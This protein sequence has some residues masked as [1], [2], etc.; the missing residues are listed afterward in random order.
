MIRRRRLRSRQRRSRRHLLEPLEI[1]QLLAGNGTG[2]SATYFNGTNLSNPVLTRVDPTVNFDWGTGSPGAGVPS[3]GF[4]ARWTGQVEITASGT[5]TF[6]TNSDD[7]VRLWVNG[8]QLVNNWTTHAATENSG[9]I[10]LTAGQKYDVT[11]EYFE[12]QFGA[13][14]QLSW[15]SAGIAK[16]IIP[17]GALFPSSSAPQPGDGTGL[18]ATYFSDMGLTTSALTRVDPTINFD[19][20]NGSPG[21][22]VPTDRFS[23]RWT[24]Q[25]QPPATGTY[26]FYTNADDGV[27]LW[28]NGQLLVD[29]WSDH[30]PRER[31]GTI[32]LVGGQKYDL[33]V[34]YYENSVGASCQVLWSSS[35]IAKQIVPQGA[36]FPNTTPD[37]QPPSVPGTPTLV[38]R[39][40]T[41]ISI[42]W[43]ASTDNVGVAGYDV[44]RGATKAGST[45]STSFTDSGLTPN[46]SY[47]YTVVA[48]DA[49]GNVSDASG[50]LTAT[51]LSTP[52][53]T[54]GG[55]GLNA[56]YFNGTNLTNPVLTRTDPTVNFDWGNGSPGA[57]VP[58]DNFSARWTGQVQA[59][60][61]GSYTFYTTSDDG[62]RLS[63]NGQQLVNNWTQHAPTENS[64]TISLVAGQKYDLVLEFFENQFGATCTFSWQGPG[65]AKQIVPQNYL[66]G[67]A[68]DQQNPSTPS[69]LSMVSR[70]D[71]SISIQWNAS[72]DNVGVAAY[73]VYR[74][75]ALAGSV[76]AP[77]TSFTD[78]N[79][80]PSTTYSYDVVARDAAGNKS[81]HSSPLS[82]TTLDSPPPTGGGTGLNATYFSNVN[83]A[84]VALT[85]VDPTINFDWGTGS[86]GAGVPVDFF[87]ARWVGQV[88]PTTSGSYTFFTNS[89]DG[90][91]LWVNGQQLVNNW[92]QHGPTENSGS[93]TLT[94]GQ[95]YD[96]VIEYYENQFGAVCQL[97]WQGP[98]VA[99]QIVPQGALFGPAADPQ[100]PSQPTGVALV[101]KTDTR[102]TIQWN[103]STDNVGVAGYDI[104]RGTTKVGSVGPTTLTFPDTGLTANTTYSYTVVAFDQAGNRSNP[105]GA[106]SVT[107]NPTSATP[108]PIAGNW[109]LIFNDDFNSINSTVWS[110]RYWW[111]GNN[112]TDA[113]FLPS[114]IS[115]SNGVLN[116]TA[117]KG[118]TTATDGITRHYAS[119]LLQSGGIQ[120]VKPAGFTFQ[121]GYV[122]ASSKVAAGNSMWSALW[123]LPANYQD[124]HELDLFENLGRAPTN[125]NSFFHWGPTSNYAGRE[126]NTGKNLTQDFHT[127]GVDWEPDHI[128]WYID[129]QPVWSYTNAA[130]IIN[131]P[132]YLILNLDVGGDWAGWPD[133][134]TPLQSTWQVDYLRV[135]QKS[136]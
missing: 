83:L 63:I 26:T 116:I 85:R 11:L 59:P 43:T 101:S 61:T 38:S 31:S 40:D 73:D 58:N 76:T 81:Q 135:W 13:V 115:V 5:Y 93:I 23:A 32:A 123:M 22:G 27:R 18:S 122:E 99:K 41:Q 54:G 9:S 86:P 1:R 127:Y 108:P 28:V 79:L 68:P 77:G 25:V 2:L 125:F 44:Y 133:G 70:T 124:T 15:S 92:T 52:P 48:R 14:C 100:P 107:T 47:S 97:S 112:G 39:T 117:V 64:G 78:N 96:I 29:D 131:R 46:T 33:K 94:A 42:Q 105:S 35:T 113:T 110:N 49:A 75:N 132:L 62:V 72:T 20:G 95:K 90:V 111:N 120:G 98:G 88:Q 55:T 60:F 3:D 80:S 69:G 91:R 118:D 103:A 19:W 10:A 119:G 106:L 45:S 136:P 87:S 56:T 57:G 7:G 84:N 4:S 121:Y 51:T 37:G 65:V 53:P 109:N 50:G 36:L 89:D 126:F 24:G 8:Q 74:N 104:F 16:Q 134:T 114:Q 102:V 128:T 17:Q 30:G 21:A 66:F 130:N 34:E 6:Y 82:V 129:G 12:Q 67:P 71:K